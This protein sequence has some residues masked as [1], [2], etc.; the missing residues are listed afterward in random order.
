MPKNKTKFKS[1][2]RVE[3]DPRI[4]S[5]WTEF[6]NTGGKWGD[7]IWANLHPGYNV[8]GCGS[9]HAFSCRDFWEQVARIK[10]GASY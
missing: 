1:L 9:I 7:E 10:N 8:D 3:S 2:N 5:V 6:A 4:E